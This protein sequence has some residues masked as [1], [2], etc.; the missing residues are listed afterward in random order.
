[1]LRI[2]QAES[3]QLIGELRQKIAELEVH[4]GFCRTRERYLI[5]WGF[6]LSES[7]THHERTNSRQQRFARATSRTSRRGSFA[8]KIFCSTRIRKRF[9]RKTSFFDDRSNR[10]ARVS[11]SVLFQ[12]IVFASLL[13]LTL[14]SSR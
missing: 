14:F 4:V 11:S 8:W 6:F 2:Q 9:S 12:L 5:L 1:M 13:V 10:V 3:T 7:R